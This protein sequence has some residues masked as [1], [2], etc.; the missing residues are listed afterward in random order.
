MHVWELRRAD[1]DGTWG[2][3]RR[4]DLRREEGA[5]GAGWWGVGASGGGRGSRWMRVRE[6]KLRGGQDREG[7]R[8]GLLGLGAWA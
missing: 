5:G 3:G 4:L 2:R 1:L 7:I 8:V 6:L